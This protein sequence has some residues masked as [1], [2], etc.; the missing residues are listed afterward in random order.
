MEVENTLVA[1]EQEQLR[2]KSL[3]AALATNR[4]TL[5]LS[6]RLYGAGQ[7]DFLGVLDA[8]R[9][10]YATEDALA[11]SHKASALEL[12]ALYKALSGGWGYE[13]YE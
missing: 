1:A 12:V 6:T 3:L 7:I 2:R 13:K 8:Q 4:Q 5:E 10:L 9:S 11:Q